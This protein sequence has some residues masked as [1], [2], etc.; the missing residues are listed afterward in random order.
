MIADND[1]T[2]SGSKK[3]KR[4]EHLRE[5]LGD[6]FYELPVTEIEN[7]LSQN[8]IAQILKKQNPKHTILIDKKFEK[9][10]NYKTKKIGKFIDGLFKDSDLKKYSEESGTIKNKLNFCQTAIGLITDFDELTDEAKA[11][12]QRII[13]FISKNN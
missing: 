6:N 7:L 12:V 9:S 13:D 1:N 5:V 2:A 10:K 4:K 3:E 11:L 8:T